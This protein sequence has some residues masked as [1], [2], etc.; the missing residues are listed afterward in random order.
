VKEICHDY[1]FGLEWILQYYTIGVSDWNWYYTHMYS[2]FVYDL[3]LHSLSYTFGREQKQTEPSEPFKQLL[4]ILPQTSSGL[5]PSP[6]DTLL[7]VSPLK[8]YCPSTFEVDMKGKKSDWEGVP[9]IPF[10]DQT[11]VTTEYNKYIGKVSKSC[12]QRN[13]RNQT[14][15]Y[16]HNIEN[17]YVFRCKT[18]NFVSKVS[19]EVFNL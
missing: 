19:K 17:S 11:T 14:Y 4:S 1:L 16:V 3:Y 12:L 18:G 8:E 6:L 10:I 13:A 5:L 9:I 7:H 15:S 2:P